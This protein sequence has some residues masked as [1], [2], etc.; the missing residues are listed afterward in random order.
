MNINTGNKYKYDN[1]PFMKSE[2]KKRAVQII[3]QFQLVFIRPVDCLVY[4][5]FN[6]KTPFVTTQFSLETK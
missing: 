5:L 2:K 3:M 4:L 1:E 6:T